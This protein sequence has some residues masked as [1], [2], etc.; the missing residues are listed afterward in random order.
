[1]GQKSN[2]ITLRKNQE[3]PFLSYDTKFNFIILNFI[4]SLSVLLNK[5]GIFLTK[6]DF[7]FNSNKIYIKL[8]LFYSTRK[9]NIYRKSIFKQKT[10]NNNISITKLLYKLQKLSKT[11]LIFTKF[12]ILK[13]TNSNN[14]QLF[15]N[16]FKKFSTVLFDKRYNLFLDFIKIS[17]LFFEKKINTKILIQVLGKIFCFLQKKRHPQFFIMIEKLFNIFLMDTKTDKSNIKGVRLLVSGK[18]LGKAIASRQL[19]NIGCVPTQTY[20][21]QIEFE[22]LHVYTLYGAFGFKIWIAKKI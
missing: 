16:S 2:I 17:S 6:T 15:Y 3:N 19:L 21:E 18:I 20:K 12:K 11:T 5:R 8:T 22:Q 7:S 10:F 4:K 14:L 13:I 9:L 1:M